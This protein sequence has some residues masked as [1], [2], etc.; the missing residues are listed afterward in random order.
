MK[1]KTIT[2]YWSGTPLTKNDI[3][4][5]AEYTGWEKGTGIS[6]NDAI[7]HLQKLGHK[8]TQTA[9]TV[10]EPSEG[11]QLTREEID[12]GIHQSGK[13]LFKDV[14]SPSNEKS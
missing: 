4:G 14:A 2:K 7:A 12:A 10:A 5:W 6:V 13:G 8:I 3:I 1:F 11:R 9:E